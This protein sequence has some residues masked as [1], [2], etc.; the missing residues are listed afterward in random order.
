M[1]Q[2]GKFTRAAGKDAKVKPEKE[3]YARDMGQRLI[4]SDAARKVAQS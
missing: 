2:R 4:T 1:G 3:E